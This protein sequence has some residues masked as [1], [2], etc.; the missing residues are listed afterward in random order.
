MPK[1]PTK[2]AKPAPGPIKPRRQMPKPGSKTQAILTLA[3]TTAASP[4][5]ITKALDC[6]NGLVGQVMERYGIKPKKLETFKKFRADIYAGIQVKILRHI[7]EDRLKKASVNNLAYALMQ[8]SQ[9]ER[10]ERGQASAIIGHGIALSPALQDAVDR[11]V[12]RDRA[13]IAQISPNQEHT[14]IQSPNDPVD[15][16]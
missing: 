9:M 6:S 15:I 7:S 8:F 5:E 14:Q 11:I 2:R 12:G 3:T 4:A 13:T 10:L 1:Q 16:A